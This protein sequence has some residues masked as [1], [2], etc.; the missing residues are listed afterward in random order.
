TQIEMIEEIL[1]N[2]RADLVALGREL[3]RNPYFVLNQARHNKVEL[4]YPEPYARSF[5]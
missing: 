3:L 4:D 1:C 5:M 2:K